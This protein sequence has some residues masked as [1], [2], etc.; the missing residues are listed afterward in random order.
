M[1]WAKGALVWMRLK[2][3]TLFEGIDI[4]LPPG[5][6]PPQPPIH[7]PT[8]VPQLPPEEHQPLPGEKTLEFERYFGRRT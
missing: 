7:P 5:I 2:S 4:I 6:P 8:P 3:F 1:K